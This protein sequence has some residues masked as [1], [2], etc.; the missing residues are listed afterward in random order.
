MTRTRNHNTWRGDQ[1]KP[2]VHRAIHR[3]IQKNLD[4]I[5]QPL[6]ISDPTEKEALAAGLTT[7]LRRAWSYLRDVQNAASDP[8]VRK[9]LLKLVQADKLPDRC[10]QV[11]PSAR[12]LIEDCYPGGRTPLEEGVKDLPQLRRAVERAL[13]VVTTNKRNGRPLGSIQV[14]QRALARS[15]A[16]IYTRF[17]GRLPARHHDPATGTEH[18]PFFDFVASV[19]DLVPPFL[20]R[21]TKYAHDPRYANYRKSVDYIVRLAVTSSKKNP[22]KTA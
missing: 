18:G 19:M 20:R 9:I 22:R 2:F 3:R 16:T 1:W 13:R 8:G 7:E 21:A 15:L 12:S 5:C 14:A 4:E 11:D 17:S 6:G 10:E